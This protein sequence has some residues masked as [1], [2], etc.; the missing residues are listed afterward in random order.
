M[1]TE[2]ANSGAA[3]WHIWVVGVLSLVWYCSG[4]YPILMAQYATMPELAADEL[5]YYA[6]KP[7][8]LELA[9]VIAFAGGIAGSIGLLLKKRW[10]VPAFLI[11]LVAVLAQNLAEL[12][13]G[14]SRAFDNQ[15]AMIVTIVIALIA[16]LNWIYARAMKRRGVLT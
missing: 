16:L 6:A 9:A 3:P 5:A 13:N 11:L 12:A 15:A 1:S 8:Y 4:A 14:T 2:N 10:A 7:V